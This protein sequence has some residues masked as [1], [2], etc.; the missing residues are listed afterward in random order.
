M[1]TSS[2][3]QII[4]QPALLV[5]VL[6]GTDLVLEIAEAGPQGAQGPVGPTGPAGP[7][8]PAG[9]TGPQGPPGSPGTSYDHVQTQ[10]SDTWTIA[11]NLGFKPAA[12]AFSVGGVE[13]IGTVTHISENVLQ[14]SFGIPVAGTARLN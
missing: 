2:N 9:P 13:M 4:E 5:E 10:P 11:H 7:Q 14:I 3:V 12:V 1:T 6:V 8:G